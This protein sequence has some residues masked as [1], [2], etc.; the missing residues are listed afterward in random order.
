MADSGGFMFRD[1]DDWLFVVRYEVLFMD[2]EN[3]IDKNS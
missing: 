2:I 1:M 3:H